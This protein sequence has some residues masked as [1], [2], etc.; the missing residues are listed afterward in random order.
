MGGARVATV[1]HAAEACDRQNGYSATSA[2]RIAITMKMNATYAA[3][4]GGTDGGAGIVPSFLMISSLL[5]GSM[6]P[7]SGG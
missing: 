6:T 7:P 4:I 3:V 5:M 2:P 1:S